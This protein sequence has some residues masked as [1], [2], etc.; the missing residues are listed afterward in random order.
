MDYSHAKAQRAFDHEWAKTE[1]HFRENGMTEDQ[2]AAMREFDLDV[3]NSDRRYHEHTVDLSLAESIAVPSPEELYNECTET[4]W[5]N[6]LPYYLSRHLKKLKKRETYCFLL[7]CGV[8]I[9]TH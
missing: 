6:L 3:F 4:E 2:I 8:R 5:I 1:A 7:P 9:I